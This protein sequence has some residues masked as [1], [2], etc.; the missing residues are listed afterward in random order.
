MFS[1]MMSV[2]GM[3]CA[4]VRDRHERQFVVVRAEQA[5]HL[6]ALEHPLVGRADVQGR[7]HRRLARRS[8]DC[9]ET[10]VDDLLQVI[11]DDDVAVIAAHQLDRVAGLDG[12]APELVRNVNALAVDDVVV[13]D[14]RQQRACVAWGELEE[15]TL[16]ASSKAQP[17]IHRRRRLASCR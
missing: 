4:L 5:L 12:R 14:A 8:L 7:E 6:D 10:R 9:D 13:G 3:R 16:A 15:R 2:V 1:R 11:A 17:A